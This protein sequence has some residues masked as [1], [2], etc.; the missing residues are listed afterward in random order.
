MTDFLNL[1]IESDEIIN[2]LKRGIQFKDICQQI[3]YERVIAKSVR[4]R[5]ITVTPEEIQAESERQR[6]ERR[7]EKAA[8]T[9]SWLA[10]QMITV[11][12][13]EAA[14]EKRLITN[15]LSKSLFSEEVKRFFAQNRIDFDQILLYQIVV[16]SEKLAQEL[17]YQISEQEI[18]FYQA[19]HLYDIDEKRRHHCGF[20][21]KLYRWNLKSD[22]ATIVFSARPG[23]VIGPQKV[24]QGYHLLMV[25]E[26][27]P[28]ELT[29][30]LHQEILDRL[31]KQW[32]AS[33]LNYMIHNQDR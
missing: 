30:E 27:I 28:S 8:D 26:F 10:E 5:G 14:I 3:L 32:L 12:D 31:F 2:F 22:I 19:A 13:W 15:K 9:L 16:P 17:L 21:G 6:R 11:E 25:D 4:E 7:L 18:S 1:L 29:T 20:E 33:E 23:E 24:A